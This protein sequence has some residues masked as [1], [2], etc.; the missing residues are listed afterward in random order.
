MEGELEAVASTGAHLVEG[1]QTR[2]LPEDQRSRKP[3]ALGLSLSNK[4]KPTGKRFLI[5]S[6]RHLFQR[7]Y[8]YT[9]EEK[10]DDQCPQ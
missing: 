2:G 1:Q 6:E 7:Q 3:G 5:N 9:L 10:Y 4:K 8:T